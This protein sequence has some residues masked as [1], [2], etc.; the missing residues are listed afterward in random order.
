MTTYKTLA[1][2]DDVHS[3]DCCG[4]S[5]L[6]STVAMEDESGE[7]VY[8]GKVCATRHSGRDIGIIKKEAKKIEDDK[9]DAAIYE[10]RHTQ[11][12]KAREAKFKEA[13][14]ISIATGNQF[15]EYVKDSVRVAELKGMEIM[16]KY[17]IKKTVLF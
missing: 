13:H 17:G 5:N 6:K 10:F 7:I 4:K 2:V 14:S 1:I 3:C 15:H 12:Y 16:E 9:I 8:F 11:E